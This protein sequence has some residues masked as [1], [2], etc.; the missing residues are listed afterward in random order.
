MAADEFDVIC[1]LCLACTDE[2]TSIFSSTIH[3]NLPK[4]LFICASIKVS[5]KDG[6]P[7]KMCERCLLKLMSFHD[8]RTQCQTSDDYLKLRISGELIPKKN[9]KPSPN[10][11]ACKSDDLNE[12]KFEYNYSEAENLTDWKRESSDED[13]PLSSLVNPQNVSDTNLNGSILNEGR[14]RKLTKRNTLINLNDDVDKKDKKVLLS[15]KCRTK[16]KKISKKSILKL[17]SQQEEALY[18]PDIKQEENS[19]FIC[20]ICNE[21]ATSKEQLKIHMCNHYSYTCKLCQNRFKT[22]QSFQSHECKN[23]KCS[24]SNLSTENLVNF[25]ISKGK[26]CISKLHCLKTLVCNFCMREFKYARSLRYHIRSHKGEKPALCTW[27]GKSF[28][29]QRGLLNHVRAVHTGEKRFKCSF[30]PK[31]FPVSGKRRQ[32]ERVHTGEKPYQCDVCFR[33]FAARTTLNAHR[34]R[35]T[36]EDKFIC[37]VRGCNQGFYAFS[38]Y[39]R[40]MWAHRGERPYQCP[41]CDKTY[42]S[43]QNLKSHIKA[44]HTKL[45]DEVCHICGKGFTEKSV[46]NRHLRKI[47]NIEP[48]D[49]KPVPA[50]GIPTTTPATI[51]NQSISDDVMPNDIMNK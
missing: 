19:E 9:K 14:K 33:L 21:S 3:K 29:E 44:I 13:V 5:H 42:L 8:F 45:R 12:T 6:L 28:T 50:Y 35:H 20:N 18:I 16:L 23:A 38:T 34:W 4:L 41:H 26:M 39:Q 32:H 30:C 49:T 22:I 40:H 15:N 43:M 47:H 46:L 51:T 31:A 27:C 17:N 1:R 48:K 2:L 37:N 36:G 25:K 24:S 10:D 7:E 11:D